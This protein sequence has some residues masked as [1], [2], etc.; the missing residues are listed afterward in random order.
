MFKL[1]NSTKYFNDNLFR[2]NNKFV[3]INTTIQMNII[4]RCSFILVRWLIEDLCRDRNI[5][6][7][8][9]SQIVFSLCCIHFESESRFR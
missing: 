8:T 5:D 1:E 9:E 7:H 3:A 2:N 4:V 6:S